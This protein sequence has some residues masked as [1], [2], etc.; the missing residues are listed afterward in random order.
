M[1]LCLFTSLVDVWQKIR[2]HTNMKGGNRAWS[3]GIINQ[4]WSYQR[5]S[6]VASTQRSW[7]RWPLAVELSEDDRISLFIS[8][9]FFSVLPSVLSLLLRTRERL[10]CMQS[11][12]IPLFSSVCLILRAWHQVNAERSQS[13]RTSFIPKCRPLHSQ[14]LGFEQQQKNSWTFTCTHTNR[15]R[16]SRDSIWGDPGRGNE[17]MVL[18]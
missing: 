1:D 9:V 12:L 7:R 4:V 16:K 15:D 8:S 14:V 2:Q 11:F 10:L 5:D 6:M 13:T 18:V 17:G 3:G